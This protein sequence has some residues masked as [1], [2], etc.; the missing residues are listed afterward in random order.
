[1]TWEQFRSQLSN[2]H[3]EA[4]FKSLDLS[5]SEAEGLFHL[6]DAEECGVIN[7]EDFIAGCLRIH[8]TA[9]AIDLTVLMVEVQQLSRQWRS[10][11]LWIEDILS[12]NLNNITASCNKI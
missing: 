3:L 11:A 8:G 10:H 7:V 6:L 12:Q 5:L 4:Y 1:M 9:K 2:P